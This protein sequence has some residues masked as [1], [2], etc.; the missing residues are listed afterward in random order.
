[1][2][3]EEIP[4]WF[5]MLAS[6]SLE[7]PHV[8]ASG[9]LDTSGLN[10]CSLVNVEECRRIEVTEASPAHLTLSDQPLHA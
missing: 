1:M 4:I 6:V 9:Y 3:R 2:C 10:L 8:T 5:L 7:W